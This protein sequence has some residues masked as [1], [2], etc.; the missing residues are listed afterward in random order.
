MMVAD[1]FCLAIIQLFA[2]SPERCA[3]IHAM[4]AELRRAGF[5]LELQQAFADGGLSKSWAL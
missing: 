2:F 3:F 5:T 1:Y 4:R